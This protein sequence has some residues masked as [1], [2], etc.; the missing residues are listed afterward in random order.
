M[1][2]YFDELLNCPEPKELFSFDD[3]P[4]NLTNCP[5]LTKEE[6]LMQIRFLKNHKTPGGDEITR[7]FLKDMGNKLS[8]FICW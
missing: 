2:R 5:T 8:T 1:N 7:G 4:K 3:S 6:I